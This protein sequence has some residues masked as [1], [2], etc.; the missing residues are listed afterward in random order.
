MAWEV[1]GLVKEGDEVRGKFGR[2]NT[3]VVDWWWKITVVFVWDSKAKACLPDLA[4]KVENNNARPSSSA[5]TPL[6]A[7]WSLVR[8]GN[9][10]Y[11]SRRVIWLLS[12]RLE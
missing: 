12:T 7:M 4:F 5:F 3:E 11:I 9:C 1:G 2:L 6:I 8:C 10:G